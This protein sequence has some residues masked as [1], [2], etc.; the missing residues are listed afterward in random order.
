MWRLVA[1]L[2]ALAALVAPLDA[3]AR[4][5]E[6]ARSGQAWTRLTDA[7]AQTIRVGG[8]PTGIAYARGSAWV[9]LA[10][11][12]VEIDGA[13]GRVKRRIA[14]PAGGDY[15]HVA[16]AGADAWVTDGAGPK[17]S[18]VDVDLAAGRVRRVV[19][20]ECCAIGIA[21]GGADVWVTVPRDG[22]GEVVRIDARTGRI[23]AR[24]PV[25]NGPGPIAIAGSRVWVWNTSAPTSL[26]AID[27]A[28]NRVAGGTLIHGVSDLASGPAGLWAGGDT[29][30]LVQID[31]H[32]GRILRHTRTVS[33]AQ[34]LAV[35][36]SAV[37]ATQATCGICDESS[38]TR[39]GITAGLSGAPVPA[40]KVAV[41]L[42]VGGGALWVADFG[43]GTVTR[44]PV[45]N[46]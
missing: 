22:P 45:Q 21:T 35:G 6:S 41:D 33:G 26:L 31:P 10:R 12:L 15:R 3:A 37:Y 23:A 42:A 5:S 18:I 1:A 36:D 32:N 17:A 40:G 39:T 38:V 27:P 28:T 46:A 16:I 43:G 2:G 11:S 9:A 29:I 20:V 13:T 34:S 14:I 19:A 8:A 25:G 30:G 24:I 44:I 7:A 4:G